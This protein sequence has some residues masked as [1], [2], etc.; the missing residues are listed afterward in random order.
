MRVQ[1]RNAKRNDFL[2][3][4]RHQNAQYP[5]ALG[6]LGVYNGQFTEGS[7]AANPYP[8]GWHFFPNGPGLME[9]ISTDSIAGSHCIRCTNVAGGAFAGVMESSKLMPVSVLSTYVFRV[10]MKASGAAITIGWGAECFDT[11]KASLGDV[12]AYNAAP[13]VAWVQA[14]QNMGAAGTAFAANTVYMRFYVIWND[15]TAGSWVLVDNIWLEM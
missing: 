5:L 13:G 4:E 10:S 3:A 6:R 11:N 14:T 7:V 15:I 1:Y 2:V 9:R 12:L 8:D